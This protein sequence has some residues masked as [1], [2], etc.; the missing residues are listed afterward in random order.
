MNILGRTLGMGA[1]ILIFTIC[2]AMRSDTRTTVDD[3]IQEAGD[4]DV[5]L[6]KMKQPVYVT[7]L[8]V[9]IIYSQNT[10]FA[11]NQDMRM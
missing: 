10:L 5:S 2:S 4:L 1:I 3:W 7:R 6:V 9:C 11:S 8:E